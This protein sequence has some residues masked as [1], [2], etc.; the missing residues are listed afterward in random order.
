MQKWKKLKA[1]HGERGLMSRGRRKI[2]FFGK[3]NMVFR[4]RYTY[5]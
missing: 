1:K 3:G 2:S 5:M 4:P